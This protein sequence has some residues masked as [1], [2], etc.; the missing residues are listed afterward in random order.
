MAGTEEIVEAIDVAG[1]IERQ[2][3]KAHRPFAERAMRNRLADD[4]AH[5]GVP[6][7]LTNRLNQ[8]V[9]LVLRP[10]QHLK[11]AT[12]EVE[13]HAGDIPRGVVV[14]RLLQQ[15]FQLSIGERMGRSAVVDEV[16][17]G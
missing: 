2:T 14:A 13:Q 15:R 7:I 3:G 1:I 12:V 11:E 17:H 8:R 5:P 16:N 9:N 10:L 4:D 6:L